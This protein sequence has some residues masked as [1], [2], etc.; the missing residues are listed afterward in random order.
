MTFNTNKSQHKIRISYAHHAN[1]FGFVQVLIQ[2]VEML[3]GQLELPDPQFYMLLPCF[4][5]Q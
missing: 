4:W 3:C 2:K 1:V 5:C